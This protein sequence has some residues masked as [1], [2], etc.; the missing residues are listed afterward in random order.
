[1]LATSVAHLNL[2]DLITLNGRNY[3]LVVPHCEAISTPHFKPSG[4][5]NIRLRI[6]FTYIIVISG[7]VP[8]DLI[9]EEYRPHECDCVL[10]F[11]LSIR[12]KP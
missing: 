5:Q 4:A 1:M 8:P 6:L 12:R 2:L 9:C 10:S 3:V 7:N 11:Q